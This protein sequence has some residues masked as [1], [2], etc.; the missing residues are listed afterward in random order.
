L[1]VRIKNR[2]YVFNSDFTEKLQ[3]YFEKL[4]SKN[5]NIPDHIKILVARDNTPNAFCVQDG[6]F[7]V[8]MGLFNW[9]DNEQQLI[10]VLSHELGHQILNHS[11]N[12]QKKII[13]KD[14]NS[15]VQVS[16]IALSKI[17]KKEKAFKLFKNH[18]YESS[19]YRR[20]SESEAD[21]IGYVLF[22]NIGLKKSEYINSLKNLQQ[23]DTISPKLVK[24]ETYQKLYNLLCILLLPNLPNFGTDPT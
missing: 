16:A 5:P 13:E 9:I 19:V 24:V 7:I 12:L 23:F 18:I 11:E 8:N 20:K 21:S 4:K 3:L 1:N 2:D 15:K 6:V 22:R 10:S 14:L 17:N